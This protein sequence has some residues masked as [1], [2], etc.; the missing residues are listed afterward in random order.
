MY[1]CMYRNFRNY[2]PTHENVWAIVIKPLWIPPSTKGSHVFKLTGSRS[3]I[4]V[5][6]PHISEHTVNAWDTLG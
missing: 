3:A 2:F 6:S 1:V 5:S 4:Y